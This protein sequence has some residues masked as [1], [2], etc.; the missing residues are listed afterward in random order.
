[1]R[2]RLHRV[3]VGPAVPVMGLRIAVMLALWAAALWMPAGPIL[4]WL[5][6]A[7]AT[8]GAVLP[9][10]L[11]TWIALGAL[12]AGNLLAAADPV[13]TA[14]LILLITSAHAFG[15]LLLAAPGRARITLR[16]L[17]PTIRRVLLIQVVT[18]PVA[19]LIGIAPVVRTTGAV[20]LAAVVAVSAS[21]ALAALLHR[22]LRPS[23]SN[24][25]G[26]A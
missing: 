11:G 12:I 1:M 26:P 13:R 19:L 4:G 16:A 25:R 20:P 22:L 14:V 15:S 5:C 23:G 6:A 7:A 24:V 18:Q 17:V 9:R 10:S 21:A 8:A 2:P 3:Q